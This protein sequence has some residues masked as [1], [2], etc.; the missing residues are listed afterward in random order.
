MQNRKLFK[1]F[2]AREC[3]LYFAQSYKLCDIL[4]LCP[5]N[6]KIN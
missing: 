3:E 6:I 1:C 5:N 2:T 4:A